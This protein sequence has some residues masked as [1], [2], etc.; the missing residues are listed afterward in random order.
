MVR[1]QNDVTFKTMRQKITS[2][3]DAIVN[4][5][6]INQT[7]HHQSNLEKEQNINE[8]PWHHPNHLKHIINNRKEM[9]IHKR[10]YTKRHRK[11]H[12]FR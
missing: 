2:C 3:D 5:H 12:L 10:M 11:C 6:A 8:E 9:R 7:I 4:T 1:I